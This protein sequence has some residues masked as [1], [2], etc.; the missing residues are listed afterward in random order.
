MI[1]GI[2]LVGRCRMKPIFR[3]EYCDK[4]GTEE[5][6][7]KHEEDCIHNYSKKS[8]HTCEYAKRDGLS[9]KCANGID[10]LEGHLFIN[11]SS[12]QWD[13]KDH[14]SRNPWALN[15]LFGGA[16]GSI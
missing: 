16:F 10:I 1:C 5:E 9:Y 15:S 7:I 14:T 2:N 6:I 11:C 4:L 3:C 13:K 8:C 12:Y